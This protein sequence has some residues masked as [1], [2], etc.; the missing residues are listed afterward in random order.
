MVKNFRILFVIVLLLSVSCQKIEERLRTERTA[1]LVREL[2]TKLDSTDVYA[3]RKEA[4]IEALKTQLGGGST[5]EEKWRLL[6]LVAQEYASSV[7]DSSLCYLDKA[8]HLAQEIGNDSLK[9]VSE[10]RR[11]FVLTSG[12]FYVASTETLLAIPRK[13]LSNQQLALYFN[14]WATLYHDLYSS[15][16]EPEAYKNKYQACYNVYRDSLLS[17]TDT[18]NITHI[19]NL[20]KKEARVGNFTEARR[21]NAIRMEGINDHKSRDYA[22]CLYDRFMLAYHYEKNLTGEAVDD[23]LE[24]AIIELENSDHDI[25]SLLRVESLLH[26][27]GEMMDAKKVSD[28]YYVSMRQLGSRKRLLQGGE[29]AMLINGQNLLLL[30]KKNNQLKIAIAFISLLAVALLVAL[31]KINNSHRKISRLKDNLQQSGKIS[32]G[33]VGVVFKLY[34]SYIRRL[35]AFRTKIYAALKRGNIEQ[36]LELTSPSKDLASEER[37]SLFRKFD[38]AFV[39]IFPDF[40]ETVNS[41]LKP[42]SQIV[43]KKTE[44]L[45]NELRI[46]ALMKLGIKD[47]EEVAD[48]LHC[49]V[50]TI[51]NLRTIFK[52][53]LAIP[54]E[55]FDRIISEL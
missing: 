28:Y 48:M 43:P 32:K 46:I 6:Y 21:Y 35:E 29:T 42:D 1:G 34:S 54:M 11:S 31:L 30:Q 14:A 2:L 17:V 50:R 27:V 33:Y 40:I 52:S 22:T 15:S 7:I 16:H 25:T 51:Y 47:N 39:D 53:R 23:L 49:T 13:D 8:A 10:I 37:R 3:A 24:S 26:D 41:C 20:E 12:G 9:N 19:R 44:I 38:G 36:A 45:N 18:T 4:Y 55:R 5:D